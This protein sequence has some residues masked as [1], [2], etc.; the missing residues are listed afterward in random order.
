[1]DDGG[2]DQDQK[3]SRAHRL[4]ADLPA[5]LRHT[6]VVQQRLSCVHCIACEYMIML[7]TMHP[8]NTVPKGDVSIYNVKPKSSIGRVEISGRNGNRNGVMIDVKWMGRRVMHISCRRPKS[9]HISTPTLSFQEF[10][11]YVLRTSEHALN[12]TVYIM[13]T[14][15]LETCKV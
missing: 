11:Y 5:I 1:M 15:Q 2:G 14:Y 6:T 10:G 7:G 4:S 8:G 12:G 3:L 9:C 13:C